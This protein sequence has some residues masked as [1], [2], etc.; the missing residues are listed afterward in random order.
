MTTIGAAYD[1]WQQ[2]GRAVDAAYIA[3]ESAFIARHYGESV[4]LGRIYDDADAAYRAAFDAMVNAACPTKG[5]TNV[6]A[7]DVAR[8]A[9]GLDHPSDVGGVGDGEA[10]QGTHQAETVTAAAGKARLTGT[11]DTW[12]EA[13]GRGAIWYEGAMETIWFTRTSLL[14]MAGKTNLVGQRVEFSVSIANRAMNVVCVEFQSSVDAWAAHLAQPR[15]APP[16]RGKSMD[17]NGK[18]RGGW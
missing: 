9:G 4:R 3:W 6:Q 2:A 15:I 14:G 18:Y 7:S 17:I 13:A 10:A 11:I 5:E 16:K 8:A 12:N 1:I